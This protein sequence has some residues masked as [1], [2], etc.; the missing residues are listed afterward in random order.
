MFTEDLADFFDVD[1][2]HAVTARYNGKYDIP[3]IF[4][5]GYLEQLGLV[6]GRGPVALVKSADV[7]T[8]PGGE[9]LVVDG[10]TYTIRGFEP[11]DDGATAL[12]RL[13][14]G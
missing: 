5:R 9:T 10:T 14:Q 6:G 2:G 3:V 11:L 1:Q 12:L 13:E 8:E 7:S 4:D